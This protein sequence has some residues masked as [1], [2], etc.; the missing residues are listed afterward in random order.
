MCQRVHCRRQ[1]SH[2]CV[3][4]F[5]LVYAFVLHVCLCTCTF[6]G[7]D[8]GGGVCMCKAVYVCTCVRGFNEAL[9]TQHISPGMG[10]S[11]AGLSEFAW[12]RCQKIALVPHS[13]VKAKR[14]GITLLA[15]LIPIIPLLLDSLTPWASVGGTKS[16][17]CPH[18]CTCARTHTRLL[19]WHGSIGALSR[20]WPDEWVIFHEGQINDLPVYLQN[21]LFIGIDQRE[22]ADI[23]EEPSAVSRLSL[24]PLSSYTVYTVCMY[25][26][27]YACMLTTRDSP[28]RAPEM[29]NNL[30][31]QVRL[32]SKCI[33]Q[34]WGACRSFSAARVNFLES[35]MN[36]ISSQ[37]EKIPPPSLF[38]LTGSDLAFNYL[39][40][41]QWNNWKMITEVLGVLSHKNIAEF[42]H[43]LVSFWEN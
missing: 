13:N 28:T 12:A 11:G 1:G 29:N 17:R 33:K 40:M 39:K 25:V 27:M 15:N 38:L 14:A 16:S 10:D 34:L 37:A 6:T 18:T 4:V 5:V 31:C 23:D 3:Y 24:P 43:N 20:V 19:T 2:L 35:E 36:F 41:L 21:C 9:L 32:Y 22:R 7:A 42:A 30:Y 26:C 8:G